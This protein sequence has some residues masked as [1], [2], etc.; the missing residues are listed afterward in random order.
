MVGH[1]A[2]VILGTPMYM[3]PE[4]AAMR[5]LSPAADW[6]AVGVLLFEM[7]SGSPPFLGSLDAILAQKLSIPAPSI[8]SMVE[9]IPDDLA[10]L[11]DE[12]LRTEPEQRPVGREVVRRL[13]SG[14]GTATSMSPR[15]TWI[16]PTTA[17]HVVGREIELSVLVE[18]QQRAASGYP[19][20]VCVVGAPGTGKSTLVRRFTE[21]LESRELDV[22]VLRGRCSAQESLPFH[23]LDPLV[24]ALARLL[25]SLPPDV[26]EPCIPEGF[27]QISTVFPVLAGIAPQHR[28]FGSQDNDSIFD[29]PGSAI[30]GPLRALIRNV[31]ERMPLVLV[32]DDVQWGD[33]QSGDALADLLDHDDAPAILLILIGEA[34]RPDELETLAPLQRRFALGQ[35]G[36]KSAHSMHELDPVSSANGGSASTASP[37]ESTRS[38]SNACDD[39]QRRRP[40]PQLRTVRVDALAHSDALKLARILFGANTPLLQLEALVRESSGNPRYLIDLSRHIGSSAPP[41]LQT[42]GSMVPSALSG[43]GAVAHLLQRLSDARI[44]RLSSSARDVL[45]A[46]IAAGASVSIEDA[47]RAA[48]LSTSASD[49]IGE[50][51]RSQILTMTGS[52]VGETAAL[53]HPRMRA[54]VVSSLQRADELSPASLRIAIPHRDPLGEATRLLALGDAHGALS[55]LLAA[56]QATPSILDR[57]QAGA[58]FQ[59]ALAESSAT[60]ASGSPSEKKGGVA[61]G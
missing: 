2:G 22:V 29:S 51:R 58:L 16:A 41:P 34:A 27:E 56:A 49:V 19:S 36:M 44:S 5:P 47:L 38:W 39:G 9:E 53:T 18:A 13:R 46:V 48:G 1:V 45:Q 31:A 50:L 52:R 6:Y 26:V 14:L 33:A 7:L 40:P 57:D 61:N 42:L 59:R 24:D 17:R 25:V 11:C 15:R 37:T 54:A 60:N 55:V 32:L 3:S 20:V 4:Q 43:D 30:V 35:G 8:R 23:A 28:S 10:E 12:L 21:E